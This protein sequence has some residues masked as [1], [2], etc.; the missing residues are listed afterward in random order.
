[1]L[2][3]LYGDGVAHGLCSS[4]EASVGGTGQ[5]ST[6]QNSTESLYEHT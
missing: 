2:M 1:M 4:L 6:R 3:P 5:T